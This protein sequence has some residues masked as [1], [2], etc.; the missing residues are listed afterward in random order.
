[1]DT[2]YFSHDYNSRNDD[3]IKELIYQHGYLGYGVFWA[4]IEDLYNNANA[5]RLQYERI[6]FDLRIDENLVKSI[7]NDFGLFEIKENHF[8]S[9]SIQKRLDQRKKKSEKAT[10]SANKRWGN[11]NAMRT[12]SDGNAI[13]EKKGKEI[14]ENKVN[15]N[16]NKFK[17]SDVNELPDVYAQKSL[18]YFYQ[19]NGT[20]ITYDQTINF[21][22]IFKVQNVNDSSDHKSLEDVYRHF[23]YWLKNQKLNNGESK[24]ISSVS[25]QRQDALVEYTKRF[26]SSG[27]GSESDIGF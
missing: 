24:Q 11:A 4:L 9:N 23:M 5:M 22:E 26:G 20:F 27:I 16:I 18:E 10:Q 13:K 15:N 3:K 1:M 17:F 6:A 8:Y 7:I 19:I 2:Y 25:Q 21:W 12:H 14:K